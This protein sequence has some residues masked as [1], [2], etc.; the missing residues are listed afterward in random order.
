M[1]LRLLTF[2]LA[3][4]FIPRF[5]FA[6][7]AYSAP[8][9][10]Q[11]IRRLTN[12]GNAL[13]VAAHPD[14]ENTRLIS[15]LSNH[16]AVNTTYISLT[17]GDGGQNLIGPELREKLGII[18]THEL[19]EA[20]KIDGGNQLFSRANDFGYS[21]TPA[22]TFNF[23]DRH[24]VLSDLVWAIRNT[25][26]DVIVCRFSTDTSRPNHGHH[27]ASAILAQEAFS[28]AADPKAF[29]EQLKFV[30]VWQ[31]RRIFFNTS[32]WFYGSQEAFNKADK[33]G[34]I[35]IDIGSY[36]PVTGESNSEIA[37]RSRSMHKSQGFGSAETRG[38]QIE[39]LMLT[40]DYKKSTP[41]SL[42]EDIDLT[43][44]RVPGGKSI[45]PLAEAIER[46]FDFKN[47]AASVPALL[48]LK[49]EIEKLPASFYKDQ[50]MEILNEVIRHALGLYL[51]A[52]TKEFLAIPGSQTEVS[53]EFINRS[54][55]PVN[56]L[57]V[58]AVG[59]KNIIQ[60]DSTLAFNKPYTA[61]FSM[62]VPDKLSIPYWLKEA[63]TSG[64]YKVSDQTL[65][66][67]PAD[68]DA[69]Q[70]DVEV[71]IGGQTITY[72][73]PVRFRTVD[74]ALGEIYRP[75]SIVPPVAVEA[76][77][78]V[79]VFQ[80]GVARTVRFTLTSL[81]DNANG[82]LTFSC[83]DPA[84][85]ISPSTFPFDLKKSGE[86]RKIEL[87]VT[88]SGKT[89]STT[90]VPQIT[91][92]NNTYHHKVSTIDYSHIPYLSIVS[93]ATTTLRSFDVQITDRRIAYLPG[94]G[95]GIPQSLA[96]IGYR[97]DILD[98]NQVSEEKLS[99]YDVIILG[100]RAFNTR[101][102]L[103][104]QNK[105]LFDWI[106]KGGTLIVQYNTHNRLVTP[107]IAPYPLNISRI[108]VS[109]E[110][111][112]V[113]IIANDSPAFN[114]PNKISSTDFE[115]WA[116]ERGLYFADK[117]DDAFTP[118]L[119]MND[120]NESPA[121]GSLLIANYGKGHYV[122]SSLSWFRHLPAG[123]PGPYRLLSN[124]I[125]LGHSQSKS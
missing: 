115:G 2:L 125:S 70:V 101:D 98:Y 87:T 107:D 35:S 60:P 11:D 42:F 78:E 58:S 16:L 109:E 112:P 31:A 49:K 93:D 44:N 75:V 20:R 64:M 52:N 118:L 18:R 99:Q 7:T 4:A 117:W 38:E 77:D 48:D 105:L 36:N 26:P 121:Q 108:R 37:G 9:I 6:Q 110:D 69:M 113:R 65:R 103:A 73:I 41:A 10:W 5:S 55:F 40:N 95:D 39:Y 72:T 25:R 104:Y 34:M 120:T 85:K 61:T 32:Y 89:G 53:L 43:W 63:S 119:E 54:S 28:L 68:P 23:W 46:D 100:V 106:K 124:L 12:T 29:P 83:P 102:E 13:Y 33:T 57:K 111:A 86:T 47:P 79:F 96:Q 62:T 30:D 97:T 14:D 123:N 27:T 15:Y 94:A 8:A 50:K 91:V 80:N 82:N 88:P 51:A 22:E 1:F 19:L 45:Q 122:Y 21:K 66:G 71:K 90:L 17:R 76:E 59:I 3:V 74:P 114:F 116:Q 81:Q 92:G 67:I 56:L 84:W 24:E